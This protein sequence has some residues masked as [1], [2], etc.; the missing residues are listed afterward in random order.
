MIIRTNLPW[1]HFRFMLDLNTRSPLDSL[2]KSCGSA[3]RKETT[4]ISDGLVLALFSSCEMNVWSYYTNM[5][6]P[7]PKNYYSKSVV[8]VSLLVWL[9]VNTETHS[10][11][12]N[13]RNCTTLQLKF[14]LIVSL[15]VLPLEQN[16][17][18]IVKWGVSEDTSALVI[19]LQ[20]HNGFCSFY[21]F[22]YIHNIVKI[23]DLFLV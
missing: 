11:A 16:N 23:L 14:F 6:L 20:P 18:I 21:Q 13:D 1:L 5:N 2:L 17:E 4:G 12:P 3:G 9:L 19:F 7:R 8:L 15:T 22:G 10:L